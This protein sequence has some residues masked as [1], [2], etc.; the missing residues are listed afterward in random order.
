MKLDGLMALN[1]LQNTGKKWIWLG[2]ETKYSGD[3]TEAQ[4][5]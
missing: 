2:V 1:T 5:G 3:G 4:T